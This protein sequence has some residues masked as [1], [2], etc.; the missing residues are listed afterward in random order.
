MLVRLLLPL[1]LL[2]LPAGSA[3]AFSH[4]GFDRIL[5]TYVK[6]GRVDYGGIKENARARL[7]A[8]VTALAQVRLTS[9]SRNERLAFYLNAYNAL[10][11][12]AVV[13]RWPE[14][15]S[16]IKIKGFF[17][18]FRYRVAGRELTLN[19]LENEVI[20]PTFADPR[21]HFA[22]VCAARSCPPL[23]ARAFR[24]RGLGRV[25]DRLA[26][27][28]VNSWRGVRKRGERFRVSKLF[29]W[30]AQDFVREAGSV[31]AYLARYHRKWAGELGEA[32]DLGFLGYSW[33]LN[34]KK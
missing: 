29:K 7:D 4:G 15:E 17:D 21:I 19:Q 3:L 13:D 26:R 30:Y 31:G 20:R 11:I 23:R 33:T 14:I 22:L 12:K 6:S 16:V 5:R 34:K 18:R 10:V 2:S 8:Y 24:A 32:K 9:M 28:F 25:L 27:G 1:L